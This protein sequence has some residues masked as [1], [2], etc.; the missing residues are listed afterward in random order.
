MLR[1]IRSVGRHWGAVF[2]K[3]DI[4]ERC[5]IDGPIYLTRK[6]YLMCSAQRIG[7]GSVIH[8]HCTFGFRP[9]SDSNSVPVLGPNVWVGPGCVIVGAVHI[10][11]GA[12]ILAGSVVTRD[13]R[14][15]T[16]MRGNP[17][18]VVREDFDNA[19]LRTTPLVVGELTV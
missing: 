1:P 13:V 14:P 12:T 5:R 16:V 8:D 10:G 2:C 17:A 11:E 15:R 9:E 6:G 18:R 4:D 3:S 7:A 19:S